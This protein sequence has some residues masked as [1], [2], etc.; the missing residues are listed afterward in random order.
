MEFTLGHPYGIRPVTGPAGSTREGVMAVPGAMAAPGHGT[1]AVVPRP[2]A[3]TKHTA[4][5]AGLPSGADL[6]R[7]APP[8]T[9]GEEHRHAG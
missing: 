8:M 2:L 1:Q 4:P 6:M 7:R 9:G 3:A 5:L